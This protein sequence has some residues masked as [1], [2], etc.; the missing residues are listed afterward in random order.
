MKRNCRKTDYTDCMDYMENMNYI[1]TGK[2]KDG[3][4]EGELFREEPGLF[5]VEPGLFCAGA[6]LFRKKVSGRAGLARIHVILMVLCAVL[7]VVIA[8]PSLRDY[9][10]KGEKVA[11]AESLR[12]VNGALIIQLLEKGEPERFEDAEAGLVSVLPGRDGYCPI[13]GTVYYLEGENGAWK[14]VC[15]L[16][17]SDEKERTR[18]NASYALSRVRERVRAA[19]RTGGSFPSQVT[20]SLNGKN[21]V[22][23]LVLEETGFRRGTGTTKGYEDAG[24]VAFYGVSGNGSF[25]EAGSAGNVGQTPEAGHEAGS[26]ADPGA[27]AYGMSAGSAVSG[28]VP[29]EVCY[30]SFADEENNATWREDDGWSGSSYGDRY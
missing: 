30:F 8:L 5:R 12:V 21:L 4:S 7:A 27:D 13:G 28:K 9:E 26:G 2:G 19:Q 16:H 15:G 17:D 23:R 3:C 29:A 1:E 10:E 18:L 25:G 22:C 11:C 24:T 20:V 14:C 6:D